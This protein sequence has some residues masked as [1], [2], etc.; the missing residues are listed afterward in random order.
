MMWWTGGQESFGSCAVNLFF[1]ISGM[2]ITAS[3]LR[4]K[5][6]PDFLMKRVL[7]IYPGFIVAVGIT[8]LVIWLLSPEFRATM[9]RRV[10][11]EMLVKDW[12]T[13][14]YDSTKWHGVFAHNPYPTFGNGSLWTIQKEFLC[15]LLTAVIGLFCLFKHRFLILL[16]GLIVTLLY[17]KAIFA[18]GDPTYDNDRFPAYFLTGMCA[19][20]WRDRIPFSRGLALVCALV[21]GATAWI[22]PWFGVLFP[23][24]GSYVVLWIGFQKRPAALDWTEKTDLSYGAYLYAFPVQ[25]IVAMNPSWRIPWLDFLIAAPVTLLLAWLSWH[26]VEQRFL[27]LKRRPMTDFDTAL[28]GL[29]KRPDE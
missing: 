4:A 3:W 15:Y 27:A 25:Q 13:L 29:E 10:W 12:L 14:S 20:L 6:M 18:G 19:W 7:R 24:A 23:L 21:L 17:A 9:G 16:A 2:L 5:S 1:L 22:T 26:F 11:L 28:V 8:G